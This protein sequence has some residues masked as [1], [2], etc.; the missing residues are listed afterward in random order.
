MPWLRVASILANAPPTSPAS[1][2][3]CTAAIPMAPAVKYELL[4]LLPFLYSLLRSGHI[5]GRWHLRRVRR[6]VHEGVC[7]RL[8]LRRQHIWQP[9]H[10]QEC[11]SVC[12]RPRGLQ[13]YETLAFFFHDKPHVGQLCTVQR[14]SKTRLFV[15]KTRTAWW[16]VTSASVRWASAPALEP[17]PPSPWYEL[18]LQLLALGADPAGCPRAQVCSMIYSPVCGCDGQTYASECTAASSGVSVISAGECPVGT[19]A[20]LN[21]A[22]SFPA[23][24]PTCCERSCQAC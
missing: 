18:L 22:L 8:R 20:S 9:L 2:P 17:A 7:A 10:G 19:R 21:S 1:W 4:Y 3:M 24:Q 5:I 14:P 23:K 15:P 12:A 13:W 11:W 6:G 16:T